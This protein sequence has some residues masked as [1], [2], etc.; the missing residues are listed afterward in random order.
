MRPGTIGAE[1]GFFGGGPSGVA[2]RASSR[3]NIARD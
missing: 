3:W 1:R 2:R